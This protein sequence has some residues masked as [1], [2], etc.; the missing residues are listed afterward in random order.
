MIRVES[1]QML[2]SHEEEIIAAAGDSFS[3]I[4][5]FRIPRISLDRVDLANLMFKLDLYYFDTETK[6]VAELDKAVTDRD[7]TLTW[8]IT[9]SVTQH[10]GPMLINL[11]GISEDGVTRWRSAPKPVYVAKTIGDVPADGNRLTELEQWELKARRMFAEFDAKE[12][13]RD[14]A[15]SSRAASESARM[16]EENIRSAQEASRVD[17]EKLRVAAEDSRKNEESVRNKGEN[18]RKSGESAREA[19]ET[20]RVNR[21]NQYLDQFPDARD[22]AR[23]SRSYA[24]GDA[25]DDN[26]SPYRAGQETDNSKYY[27]EQVRDERENLEG[28]I[29]THM[30]KATDAMNAAATGTMAS[31]TAE[32]LNA[33]I[34]N[35]TNPVVDKSLTVEGAAADAKISGEGIRALQAE[36]QD[37]KT[38]TEAAID[39]MSK[40]F[41]KRIDDT[42]ENTV[43]GMEYNTD[44]D[45]MLYLTLNGERIGDGVRVVGGSGGSGGGSGNNAVITAG[46]TGGWLTKTI[47]S[48]T[49]CQIQFEWSSIENDMETGDGTAT[50]LIANIAKASVGIHQGAVT[51][52][53]TDYLVPGTNRIKIRINDVYNN[54][55]TLNYTVSL[56]ELSIRSSFNDS[57]AYAKDVVFPYIATGDAEKI[58]HFELDG[59]EIGADTVRASGRQRIFIIPKQR[60][61]AHVF[62]CWFICNINGEQVS[63]NVL[64]YSLIT[65]ETGVTAVIISSDFHETE[66]EQ[67]TSLQI[68]YQV[69]DPAD[70]ETEVKLYANNILQNTITVGRE[71]QYWTYRPDNVGALT[72]KIAAGEVTKTFMLKVKETSIPAA[73]ETSQQVL[74]LTSYGRS[75]KEGKPAVWKSGDIEANLTGF[76]FASDGWQLDQDGIT[77]LRVSGDA[78]VEIPYK[79]CMADFRSTGKTIEIEFATRYVMNYDTPIV[80]CMSGGRG[81]EVTSQLARLVSEQ[82]EISTQF[83]EEEHVR[84]GFVVEKRSDHHRLIEIYINGIMSGAKI[85][86]DNDDFAQVSPVNI[87]IGTNE[88]TVDIYNIRIYD[89]NLTREQMLNNWIA[90]TQIGTLRKT[91]FDRNNIYNAYGRIAINKLPADLPYMIL[92]SEMPDHPLLPQY[93]GDKVNV[94]VTYVDPGHSSRSFTAEGAQA[95]VQGTSSQFYPRKNYKIKF[96]KGFVMNDGRM[97]DTYELRPGMIG[98]KEFCFKADVASSEGANNVE[99]VRAYCDSC[100]YETPAQKKDSRVRQGIDG[101]PIVMFYD[102]GENTSFLGKYNFNLD[103]GTPEEYGFTEGDESWEI[104]N[105]TSNRVLWKSND[106]TST[107]SDADGK[108]V[109]E[110]RSDFEARFPDQ[111][112]SYTD[113]TQLKA[114]AD[115]IVS[116]DTEQATNAVLP[117]A[118]SYEGTEYTIDSGEYRLAKFKAEIGNYVEMKSTE[119]YYLFTELFLMVDS[120]AKNAFPSFIGSE[121][122]Q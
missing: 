102:D 74:Y 65:V 17:A 87:T 119:F 29:D 27:Y 12:N 116:T 33:N 58:V 31:K 11:R 101:F 106:Y 90:D 98:T 111:E 120:R 88:S 115:W 50:I 23:K 21:F 55:R 110:W 44:G 37:N 121:V 19:A 108:E 57:Q 107:G 117:E 59:A 46:N 104:L 28:R 93:K 67:Y 113:P 79:P 95:N 80:S 68:P 26:G 81:F 112:P 89:N 60:H 105:N 48:G 64:Q 1:K 71:R 35:P 63:S 42:A 78:R 3:G 32:W 16:Q 22:Y 53:I 77:V 94:S 25:T 85:Y 72:L 10:I 54:Q 4:R 62:R 40:D 52:D 34:T 15:E 75:N 100:P 20:S 61:G 96:K 30:Q 7:V 6:D 83:K 91:R 76:N 14:A 92:R 39:A 118:V 51:L 13:V 9:D 73:A 38:S 84:V 5:I 36:V 114:F 109:P 18:D 47:A 70:L 69:Y 99:L 8:T 24:I 49:A 41:S 2:F 45:Y 43:N 103:K 122:T 97:A 82:T 56:L 86:P 66:T